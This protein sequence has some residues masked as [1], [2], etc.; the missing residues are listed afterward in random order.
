MNVRSCTSS[1]MAKLRNSSRISSKRSCDQSTRSILLMQTTRC[2]MPSRL[3]M[4]ACRRDC[5]STPLRA[6]MRI[7]ARSAVE[8]PVTMLRVYWMCPG[9][10]AMM[11]LRSRRGEV[12]VGHVDGDALL[13]LGPQAVGQQRQVGVAVAPLAAGALHR[14]E[15][16]REDRLG[17]VEQPADQGGLAVV[18]AAG[19]GQAQQLGHQ[20]YPSFL[21]SS[22]PASEIRSSARVAPRSVS[23]EAATSATTCSVVN[24]ADST[25]PVQVASPMVRKR[26][27][28]SN[29]LLAVH[30]A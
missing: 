23:R 19:G 1:F 30:H 8:A 2:G 5:S 22:M 7:R 16:V 3:A 18:D 27:V 12:P 17:V 15:L 11:N 10:S 26:T 13:P 14:V 9:V 28:A 24:A 29:G 25:Q 6:S 21:R 4:K 20:K